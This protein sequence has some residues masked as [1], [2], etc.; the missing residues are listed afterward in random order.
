MGKSKSDK[1]LHTEA[2]NLVEE[3]PDETAAGRMV[4]DDGKPTSADEW[5][6][7]RSRAMKA[8]GQQGQPNQSSMATPPKDDKRPNQ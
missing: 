1:N 5:L 2:R 6:R 3:L 8:K 4:R 7:D